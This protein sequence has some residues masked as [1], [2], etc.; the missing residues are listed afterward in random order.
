MPEAA[1]DEHGDAHRPEYD[2]G[3]GSNARHGHH[4]N[5]VAQAES[6]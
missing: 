5:P 2:I 3:T 4:V 6:M 1:V